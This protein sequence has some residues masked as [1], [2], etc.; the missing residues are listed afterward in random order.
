MRA[1][2]ARTLDCTAGI[3]SV[4]QV[5]FGK[6]CREEYLHPCKFTSAAVVRSSK[7][8]PSKSIPRMTSAIG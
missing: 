4:T 8:W 3:S 1:T 5:F 7:G 6:W 2:R